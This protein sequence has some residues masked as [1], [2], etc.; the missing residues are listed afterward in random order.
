MT[1]ANSTNET[2]VRPPIGG[3]LRVMV[4]ALSLLQLSRVL[5]HLLFEQARVLLRVLI[6]VDVEG[7]ELV[8]AALLSLLLLRHLRAQKVLDLA[9][10]L[11][12]LLCLS[13]LLEAEARQ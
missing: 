1:F 5:G 8:V 10:V 3:A 7:Q 4:G 13:L 12:A 6:R 2:S 11:H 9:V